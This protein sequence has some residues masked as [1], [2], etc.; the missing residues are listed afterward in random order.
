MLAPAAAA[1]KR[2]GLRHDPVGHVAAVRRAHHAKAIAIRNAPRDQVIDT[3]HDVLV[4]RAAPVVDDHAVAGLAVTRTAARHRKQHRVTRAGKRLGGIRI[5]LPRHVH[6]LGEEAE[7]HAADG[8]AVAIHEQWHARLAS[9][10]RRLVRR[11]LGGG[12]RRVVAR[13]RQQQAPDFHAVERL[14]RD[15]LELAE[16]EIFQLRIDGRERLR[17]SRRHIHHHHIA[18]RAGP[19]L[20]IGERAAVAAEAHRVFNRG[21]G[22]E[23]LRLAVGQGDAHDRHFEHVRAGGKRSLVHRD[24]QRLTVGRPEDLRNPRAVHRVRADLRVLRTRIGHGQAAW[25]NDAG[26]LAGGDEGQP[27]AVRART[28]ATRSCPDDR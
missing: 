7:R 15:R 24:E 13:R 10:P 11:S 17:L 21:P 20:A 1:L 3:G 26:A 4:I 12:G 6:E 25:R 2:D 28:A 16:R 18:H 5:D 22:A 19:H 23:P 27:L 14:P 9:L 8:T